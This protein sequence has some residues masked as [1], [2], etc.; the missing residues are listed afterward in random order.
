MISG[1]H[2]SGPRLSFASKL[3]EKAKVH[4]LGKASVE[5]QP[6][7]LSDKHGAVFLPA[8]LFI[9]DYRTLF[10]PR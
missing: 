3:L 8:A 1:N 9:A 4:I 6:I 2:D 7:I 10:I 5:I